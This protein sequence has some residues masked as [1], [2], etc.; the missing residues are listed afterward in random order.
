M[1]ILCRGKKTGEPAG[2]KSF[3]EGREPATNTNNFTSPMSE[4]QA[5]AFSDAVFS[6]CFHQRSQG[7]YLAS[8]EDNEYHTVTVWDWTRKKKIT[9]ARVRSTFI[10]RSVHASNTEFI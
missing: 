10:K 7:E 6:V 2:E 8:V 5:G 3:E 4:K 9:S 1:I